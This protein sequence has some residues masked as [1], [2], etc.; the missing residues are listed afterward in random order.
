MEKSLKKELFFIIC[1]IVTT[2]VFSYCTYQQNTDS[3]D[4][5]NHKQD[6]E[7]SESD[8]NNFED[9][10]ISEGSFKKESMVL[11]SDGEYVFVSG[12]TGINE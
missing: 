3:A 4:S 2:I 5:N 9:L 1:L 10:D 6:A 12:Y 8:L 7:F 11:V